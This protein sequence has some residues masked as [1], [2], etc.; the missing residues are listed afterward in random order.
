MQNTNTATISRDSKM[1]VINIVV[2]NIYDLLSITFLFST[3]IAGVSAALNLL[4]PEMITP[5]AG[6]FGLLFINTKFRNFSAEPDLCFRT[7]EL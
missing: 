1:L 6:Y 4:H 3:L 7:D 2:R 5:L